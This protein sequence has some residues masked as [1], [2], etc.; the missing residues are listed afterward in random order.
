M[1]SDLKMQYLQKL[2]TQDLHDLRDFQNECLQVATRSFNETLHKNRLIK[3]KQIVKF[4]LQLIDL[5]LSNR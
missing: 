2:S 5:V 1:M 3:Q 4:N